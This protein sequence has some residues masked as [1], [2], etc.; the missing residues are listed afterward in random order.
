[1]NL[2]CKHDIRSDLVAMHYF[3]AGHKTITCTFSNL[4]LDDYMLLKYFLECHHS[5]HFRDKCDI[6]INQ[7][8]G[9]IDLFQL[10]SSLSNLN[11]SNKYVISYH[12]NYS[13]FLDVLQIND[14]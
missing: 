7:I 10:V 12:I 4:G 13:S 11:S 5:A 3:L 8:D 1:M 9:Q 6:H 14:K 2:I